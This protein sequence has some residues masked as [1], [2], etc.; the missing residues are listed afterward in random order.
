MGSGIRCA[1]AGA[2]AMS[3]SETKRS[4]SIAESSFSAIFTPCRVI[5]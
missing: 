2:V 5:A 1:F 3:F 4:P